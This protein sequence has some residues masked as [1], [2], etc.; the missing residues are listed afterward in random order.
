MMEQKVSIIIPC[1]NGEKFVDRCFESLLN[2]T[3]DRVEVIVVDD[4]STDHSRE[5]IASYQQSF[6]KRGYELN[7]QYQ[8]NQGAGGAVNSGLKYFTGTFFTLF[9]IDDVMMPLSIEKKVDFLLKHPGFDLVRTNG[10]YVNN[11]HLDKPIG[12]F[13]V[14]EREKNNQAIFADLL[15]GKTNNWAGTYLIRSSAF[16]KQVPNRDI[17]VTRYGQNL[18]ILLPVS[19]YGKSGFIDEPLV[20]YVKHEESYSFTNT[21]ARRLELSDGYEDIRRNMLK[22]MKID[23][24]KNVQEIAETYA[25]IKLNIAYEYGD[26]DLLKSQYYCLKKQ[27]SIQKQDRLIYLLGLNWATNLLIRVIAKIKRLMVERGH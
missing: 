19:Y 13:V 3:Y 5:L 18:Q 1:Y 9:D 4:G 10:Y 11:D 23:N 24:A 25:R 2:Q 26:K 27:G 22:R 20:K 21:L 6:N 16:L 17:Y 14:D 8:E 12:L 7:Y 15:T